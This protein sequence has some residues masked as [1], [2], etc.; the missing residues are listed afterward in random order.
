MRTLIYIF[1]FFVSVCSLAQPQLGMSASY[2]ITPTTA[3][4][5]T[6]GIP[7]DSV[8][9]ITCRIVNKGTASFGPG[10][11]LFL[12][13]AV[14]SGTVTSAMRVVYS[15][16]TAVIIPGDSIT[17]T[18]TDS[19]LPPAYKVNGNGN[20]IVVWPFSSFATTKDSLKAG[21]VYVSDP[22]GIEEL[23]R[24]KL[25]IYPNPTSQMLFIQTEQGKRYKELMIYDMQLKELVRKPFQESTD[26]GI[27]PPGTYIISVSDHEGRIYSSRF[28]KNN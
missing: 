3:L 26:I 6:L 23:D 28:I 14:K 1:A 7:Y 20:T 12:Q 16:S 8:V 9:K 27:L 2:T 25:F 4:S 10:A 15:S 19:V 5:P 11:S 22:T 24:N 17:V 13:R 21:P 18:V